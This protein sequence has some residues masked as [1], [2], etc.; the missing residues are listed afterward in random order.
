MAWTADFN[1]VM[2][3]VV[4]PDGT[5]EPATATTSFDVTGLSPGFSVVIGRRAD[6]RALTKA[7]P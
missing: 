5:G 4:V 2:S 1:F 3:M 7:L 6:S